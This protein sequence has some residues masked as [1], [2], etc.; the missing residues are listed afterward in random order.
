MRNLRTLDD[1][2]QAVVK[3]LQEYVSGEVDPDVSLIEKYIGY[4]QA[5]R[6][7]VAGGANVLESPVLTSFVPLLTRILNSDLFNDL[8]VKLLTAMLE[9][10]PFA[11]TVKFFPGDFVAEAFA[12]PAFSVVYLAVHVLKCRLVEH[13]AAAVEFMMSSNC[14]DVLLE[15]VLSSVDAPVGVVS[16]TETVVLVLLERP[17][18]EPPILLL[19]KIKDSHVD[20]DATLLSRYLNVALSLVKANISVGTALACFDMHRILRDDTDPFVAHLLCD[21]YSEV[22]GIPEFGVIKDPVAQCIQYFAENRKNHETDIFADSALAFLLGKLTHCK[23]AREWIEQTVLE[24]PSL[25]TFDFSVEDETLIFCLCNLEVIPH[26]KEYFENFGE[27]NIELMSLPKFR[28]IL[29]L[30]S[31]AEFFELLVSSGKLTNSTL[32]KL[33]KNLIYEFIATTTSKDYT[34]EYLLH[35]LPN[36]VLTYLIANDNSIVNPEIWNWKSQALQA[37]LMYRKVD[38]GVWKDGLRQSYS[39]M[40]NGRNVRN[41]QPQVDVK[42]MA[43]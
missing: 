25:V 11:D 38:L 26:K 18:F 6:H 28:C 19:L 22:V 29:H 16:D 41:A 14:L 15:R 30:M 10:L 1:E 42:D 5:D 31:N 43:M 23:P 40:L 33:P 4:I 12:S 21:F 3:H 27:W 9:Q 8:Y 34:S 39:E 35:E 2:S 32:S 36:I 20:N 24:L 17:D 37:L 7:V 13:D